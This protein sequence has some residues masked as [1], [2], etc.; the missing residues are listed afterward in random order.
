MTCV[1]PGLKGRK[2]MMT[3]HPRLLHQ[4][5]VL[6]SVGVVVE[7]H[8]KTSLQSILFI[9]IYVCNSKASTLISPTKEVRYHR[10]L[11]M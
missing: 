3:H 1:T 4:S 7:A 11:N 2:K 5:G 8:S 9:G 10:A 6:Q